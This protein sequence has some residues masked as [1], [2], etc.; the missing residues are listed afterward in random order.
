MAERTEST[1][2]IDVGD[3]SK[4]L[5]VES[6]VGPRLTNKSPTKNTRVNVSGKKM[7]YYIKSTSMLLMLGMKKA[8]LG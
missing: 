6:T 4:I 8:A 1:V 7:T 5:P 3:D 2:A